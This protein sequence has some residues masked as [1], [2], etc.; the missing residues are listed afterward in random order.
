MHKTGVYFAEEGPKG[1]A[2]EKFPD[3]KNIYI[4]V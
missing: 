3:I 2:L 4:I 1:P